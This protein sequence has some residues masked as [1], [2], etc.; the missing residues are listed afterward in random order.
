MNGSKLL[1]DGRN[2]LRACELAGIEPRY[3]EIEFENDDEIWKFVRSRSERRDLT[4]GERAM[5]L[6]FLYPEPGKAHRGKKG[7]SKSTAENAG[8]SLRRLEQARAV[9]RYSR[10]LAEAVRDGVMTLDEA[11][12]RV[13][14]DQRDLKSADEKHAQLSS[15]APD[16]ADQVH[17][18]KLTLGEAWA[19]FEQR[20]RDAA[21]AEDNKRETLLRLSEAAYRGTIA[22]ANDEFAADVLDR[23]EDADFAQRLID[24]LRVDCSALTE[25][26]RGANALA[27]MLNR[28]AKKGS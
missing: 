12:D 26:Q 15:E 17:K 5:L 13:K 18:E 1:V 8:L 19:A 22:W 20:K 6:A 4:K 27:E 11:L 28:I 25:I 10:E 2:R 24:R 16:L 21:A 23:L 3:E 14:T 9:Y 7:E